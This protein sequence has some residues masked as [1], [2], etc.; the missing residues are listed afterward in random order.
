MV[1][2]SRPFQGGFEDFLESRSLRVKD[3]SGPGRISLLEDLIYY[4]TKQHPPSFNTHDPSLLALSYYP[5]KIVAA[6]WVRYVEVLKVCVKEYEYSIEQH[7]QINLL[8]RLN[9][10]LR[11]LRSWIRR[12]MQT[13][14][15][16][17]SVIR[18]VKKRAESEV[19]KE[20]YNLVLEDYQH[21]TEVVEMYGGD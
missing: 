2:E 8:T 4:F 13:M 12:Y 3:T 10:D 5:L 21:L 6:E 11:D 9:S 16:L 17:R 15:K 18:F 19:D 1:L 14:E 7:A 20:T